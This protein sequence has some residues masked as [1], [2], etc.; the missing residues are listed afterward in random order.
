M[1]PHYVRS[2][3]PRPHPRNPDRMTLLEI[4]LRGNVVYEAAGGTAI[5]R[6]LWFTV[7]VLGVAGILIG[8]CATD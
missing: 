2:R 8:D 7:L 3:P 5:L 6:V 4:F 1:R